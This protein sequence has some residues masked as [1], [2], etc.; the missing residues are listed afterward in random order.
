MEWMR[1]RRRIEVFVVR[2]FVAQLRRVPLHRSD[3]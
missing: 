1:S 2:V 3:S